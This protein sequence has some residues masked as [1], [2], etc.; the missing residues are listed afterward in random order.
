MVKLTVAG[1]RGPDPIPWLQTAPPLLVCPVCA[2]SRTFRVAVLP[3][4]EQGDL[5]EEIPRRLPQ[6]DGG[7]GLG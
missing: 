7:T 3:Q 5:A 1:R 2:R 6:Q 4:P